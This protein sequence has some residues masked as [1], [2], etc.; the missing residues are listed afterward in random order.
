ML[1]I[2]VRREAKDLDAKPGRVMKVEMQQMTKT[3]LAVVHIYTL[4]LMTIIAIVMKECRNFSLNGGAGLFF[5][6]TGT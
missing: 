3:I 5:I 1:E 2:A 4:F 6:P